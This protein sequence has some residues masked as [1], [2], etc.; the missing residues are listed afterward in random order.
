MLSRASVDEVSIHYF[1][2]MLSA[3]G[4]FAPRPSPGFC[5][6][7]LLGLPF[8][9]LPHCPPP[10]KSCRRPCPRARIP[11]HFGQFVDL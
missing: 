5:H 4:A 3:F 11:N 9:R 8:F 1:E 2:K 6:W 7:T 10:E